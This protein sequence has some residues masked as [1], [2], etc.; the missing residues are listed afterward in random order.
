MKHLKELN[1]FLNEKIDID[2]LAV[3]MIDY[4]GNELPKKA[5]DAKD[6][7]K[8]REISDQATVKKIWDRAKEIQKNGIDE[9]ASPA[10]GAERI[11]AHFK[12]V[13]EAKKSVM[14]ILNHFTKVVSTEANPEKI[15][16]AFEAL[17]TVVTGYVDIMK[18]AP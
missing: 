5:D 15:E 2:L 4:Y 8:S 6:F 10:Y 9:A 11:A 12:K 16:E 7:A 17:D 18:T 14:N 13:T 1:N 3:D